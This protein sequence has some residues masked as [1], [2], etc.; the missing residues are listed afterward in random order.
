MNIFRST[1]NYVS[2][3][4]IAI[5]LTACAGTHPKPPSDYYSSSKPDNT[6]RVAFDQNGHIYPLSAEK[7]DWNDDAFK[8]HWRCKITGCGFQLKKVTRQG[9]LV[10][11]PETDRENNTKKVIDDLNKILIGKEKLAVFIH[12]F[13]NNY[14]DA[15]EIYKKFRS[16]IDDVPVLEVYWDG[17]ENKVPLKIWFP[18]LTYSNLAGQIG[19]RPILNGI[20][21][22]IDISIVTHSRGAAVAIS[23]IS[24][25][26]YDSGIEAPQE[27]D[28]NK[29]A[30]PGYT[31]PDFEKITN[32]S[33]V[34]FAPAIGNG[35]FWPGIDYF[36]PHNKVT[37]FY[38][39]TNPKD[40]ATSKSI[41]PSNAFGDTSLGGRQKAI[42]TVI[43]EYSNNNKLINIQQ[44]KFVHGSD[45][46]IPGYFSP[47]NGDNPECMLWASGL[48]KAKPANCQLTPVNM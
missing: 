7:W 28:I 36:L 9:G 46:G 44:I 33:F 45:H 41:I 47:I 32:I 5:F 8:P 16:K 43:R 18:A 10:Y 25:P 31:D 23:A 1:I 40:F 34:F 42:D 11:D 14:D 48:R 20:K 38:L 37:Y 21:N 15:Q 39:G 17:V 2:G 19:L 3:G 30:F 22:P 4:L 35:H 24:N 27:E 12:G 6:V 13:N 26:I 29:K